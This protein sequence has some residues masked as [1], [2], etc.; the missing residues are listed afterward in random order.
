VTA[1]DA[2]EPYAVSIRLAARRVVASPSDLVARLLEDIARRCD[3][4]GCSLV[5]H[6]K[7]HARGAGRV[8]TCSLTSRR[9]GA[10]CRGA[11]REPMPSGDTLHVDLVVLVYGLRR[12]T[13]EALVAE[14]LAT[15]ALDADMDVSTTGDCA[16]HDDVH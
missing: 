14:G 8:F 10:A 9:T 11:G 12:S 3:E 7:C 6:I 15:A 5:G 2:L 16:A 4:A 13:I 1:P